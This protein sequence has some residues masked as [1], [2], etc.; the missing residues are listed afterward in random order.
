MAGWLNKNKDP[1]NDSVVELFKKSTF[2]FIQGLWED[3]L[4]EAERGGGSRK[5]G[6]QF[7]TMGQV[8]M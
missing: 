4:A 5:K 6:S 7:I 2:P 1:L 3:H 8:C